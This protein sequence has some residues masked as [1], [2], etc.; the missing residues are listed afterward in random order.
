M[1]VVKSL[2]KA[3]PISDCAWNP[4][5]RNL[6]ASV[7][8]DAITSVWDTSD[9][10]HK[11]KTFQFDDCSKIKKPFLTV[12]WN[13]CTYTYAAKSLFWEDNFFLNY[14]FL[15]VEKRRNPSRRKLRWW[16]NFLGCRRDAVATS[17]ERHGKSHST[18]RISSV[19][20]LYVGDIVKSSNNKLT[21]QYF[22]GV[23]CCVL[24]NFLNF[25]NL[26][27]GDLD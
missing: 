14:G 25:L 7:S 19:R 5:N 16:R 15:N 23:I 26:A 12:A 11:N 24:E 8:L 10:P 20:R 17:S 2:E 22:L 6:L 9:S 1:V 4:V 27:H 13:V 21:L 18:S 3:L